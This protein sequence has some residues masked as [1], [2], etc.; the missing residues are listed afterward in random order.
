MQATIGKLSDDYDELVQENPKVTVVV[1]QLIEDLDQSFR[2][3][4]STLSTE[5]VDLRNFVEGE[6]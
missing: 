6:L 4:V 3:E 2:S 1:K 5:V